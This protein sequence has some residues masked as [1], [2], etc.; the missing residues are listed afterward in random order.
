MIDIKDK[1][2][3]TYLNNF[4]D[5]DHKEIK[6]IKTLEHYNKNMYLVTFEEHNGSYAFSLDSLQRMRNDYVFYNC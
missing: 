1:I 5:V 6:T 4:N 2:L 3:I